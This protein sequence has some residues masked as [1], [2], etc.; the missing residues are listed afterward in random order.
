MLNAYNAHSIA[1]A[2]ELASSCTNF[3]PKVAFNTSLQTLC[4]YSQTPLFFLSLFSC[5]FRYLFICLLLL[6]FFQT[7]ILQNSQSLSVTPWKDWITH[8]AAVEIDFVFGEKSLNYYYITRHVRCFM[9]ILEGLKQFWYL[10]TCKNI[11][12]IYDFRSIFIGNNHS[13]YWQ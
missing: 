12:F 9:I 4:L 5:S 7:K 10:L 8:L 11:I 6:S 13:N 3:S 1:W 2:L